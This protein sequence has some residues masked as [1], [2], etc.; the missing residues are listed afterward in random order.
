MQTD[1]FV[2]E[3]TML[4][5]SISEF[6]SMKNVVFFKTIFL[7]I[8]FNTARKN[9]MDIKRRGKR[10]AIEEQTHVECCSKNLLM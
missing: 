3:Q 9:A 8:N 7:V 5:L 2:T 10:I 4:Y 1:A 6:S